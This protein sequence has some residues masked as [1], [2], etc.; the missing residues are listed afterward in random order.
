MED[1]L[2]PN[3]FLKDLWHPAS[4]N[5]CC[6]GQWSRTHQVRDKAYPVERV[7]IL[8]VVDNGLVRACFRS[9]NVLLCLV[10]ILVPMEDGLVPNEFLKDLWHPASLNLCCSGQ[11]SRTH[12]VRDKAYPVERVLILIVVDNGLVRP[13]T[14][15]YSHLHLS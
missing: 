10:I 4:L 14:I 11:W 3:E 15:P 7:L 9:N 13:T 2:V 12:Q 8:I 1:G 5:L 6:S